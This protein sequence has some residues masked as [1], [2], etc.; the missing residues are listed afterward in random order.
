MTLK[1]FKGSSIPHADFL[2]R[3]PATLEELL[4]YDDDNDKP[5]VSMNALSIAPSVAS[6][7]PFE[8]Q[9]AEEMHNSDELFNTKDSHKWSWLIEAQRECNFCRTKIKSFT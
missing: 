5:S 7:I 1:L 9:S 4:R 8:A 3:N 2:S 6:S